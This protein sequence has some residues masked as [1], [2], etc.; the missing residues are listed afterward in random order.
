MICFEDLYHKVSI[1]DYF[2]YQDII[3]SSCRRKMIEKKKWEKLEDLDIFCIYEYD[4]F[5]ESLLFQFKEGRD[6]ALKHVFLHP[7]VSYIEKMFKDY[8]IIYIPSYKEHTKGRGFFPL[9]EMWEEINLP[10]I[11]LFEKKEDY[12][13]SSMSYENRNK[14]KNKIKK[15]GKIPLGKILLVD[16]VITSGN[17][18]L[19]V[20]EILKKENIEMKALVLCDNHFIDKSF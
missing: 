9:E 14:I 13:Q 7:Y 16:D 17:T 12:K 10:K 1:F 6:I 5:M 8:T 4:S 19:S 3:C 18:L 11:H 2:T 15:N 20:Y